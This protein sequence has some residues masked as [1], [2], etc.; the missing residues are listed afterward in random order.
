MNK[1]EVSHNPDT[2]Q[3]AIEQLAMTYLELDTCL[4]SNQSLL[5]T[6]HS[7]L[8]QFMLRGSLTSITGP[9]ASLKT[10]FSL[11]LSVNYFFSK[12]EKGEEMGSIVYMHTKP[13]VNLEFI[14]KSFINVRQSNQIDIKL[15]D[16][17][18]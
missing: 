16:F 14:I 6:T 12:L 1:S 18:K 17:L 8:D 15:E 7:I 13:V 10:I 4:N 2:V 5:Q 9:R 3:I 11:W